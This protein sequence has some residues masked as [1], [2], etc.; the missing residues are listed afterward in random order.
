VEQ[1]QVQDTIPKLQDVI[2]AERLYL[3]EAESRELE[4]LLTKCRDIFAMKN[5]DFGRPDRVYNGIDM[6][7]SRP[8]RQPSRKLLLAK[9]AYVGEMLEDM[10]RRGVTEVRQPR[11]IPRHCRPEER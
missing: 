9:Q 7:E 8:I 5:E 2:A 3:T 6:R 11:I 4:E 1:P 10:Q